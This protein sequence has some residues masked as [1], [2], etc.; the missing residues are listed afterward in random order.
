MREVT[1]TAQALIASDVHR[2]QWVADLFYDGERIASNLPISNPQLAWDGNSQVAGSGS[3]RV[4]FTD[5]WAQPQSPRVPGDPMSPFGFELQVDCIFA[6]SKFSERIALGRY[7]ITNLPLTDDRQLRWNGKLIVPATVMD[8]E[9]RD[10][11]HRVERYRF[12]RPERP[13]STS[14]WTE[15]SRLT[16]LPII[17]NATDGEVPRTAVYADSRLDALDSLFDRMDAWPHLTSMGQLTA[18]PYDWPSPMAHVLRPSQTVGNMTSDNIYNYVVVE[19]K[20][21]AGSPVR[22]EAFVQDGP[23]RAFEPN[24]SI[25]PYGVVT[26]FYSSDMITKVH[27]AQAVARRLLNEVS[28]R[29]AVRVEWEEPFNPLREVG[30]VLYLRGDEVRLVEVELGNKTRCSAE[31]KV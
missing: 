20:T 13:R 3:V 7:L 11:L 12:P 23:L 8:L 24:G 6:A 26:Y 9:L 4:T 19:G 31:L 18:R 27:Q 14:A 25:G 17:R 21:P 10:L 5:K 29:R 30:D 22:G 28:R 16:S 2:V 1:A 15:I